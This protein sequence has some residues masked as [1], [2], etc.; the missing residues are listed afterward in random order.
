[1][2]QALR[3]PI[4]IEERCDSSKSARC[5][6]EDHDWCIAEVL[7]ALRYLKQQLDAPRSFRR[8]VVCPAMQR[9]AAR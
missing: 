2:E 1:L 3:D 7:G 9:A 5:L 6:V 8:D 4:V